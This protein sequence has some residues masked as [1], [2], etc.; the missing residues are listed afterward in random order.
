MVT[1]DGVKGEKRGLAKGELTPEAQAVV[2]S[3][4]SCVKAPALVMAWRFAACMRDHS[5]CLKA[6]RTTPTVVDTPEPVVFIGAI[7]LCGIDPVWPKG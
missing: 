5:Q 7:V 3:E 1:D 4:P 6:V 2:F